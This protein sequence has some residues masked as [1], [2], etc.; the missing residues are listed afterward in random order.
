[1]TG[2]AGSTSSRPS[3]NNPRG[4]NQHKHCPPPDDLRVP[5]LLRAYQRQGISD[6]K[7]ISKLLCEEHGIIMS[8]GTVAR[9]RRELGLRASGRTTAELPDEVKRQLVLDQIGIGRDPEGRAGA[10]TVKARI[11]RETGIDLTRAYIRKEMQRLKPEAY[12]ART[13]HH[14]P[15]DSNE[16][17]TST[18]RSK[19]PRSSSSRV[20]R[21]GSES[22][23]STHPTHPP[24][25]P[26]KVV[27]RLGN[28]EG[29]EVIVID[30][31]SDIDIGPSTSTLPDDSFPVYED[32]STVQLHPIGP[33]PPP[34]LPLALAH[35]LPLTAQL[36]LQDMLEETTP[37]MVALTRALRAFS[38]SQQGQVGLDAPAHASTAVLRCMEAAAMLERELARV[39][40][41]SGS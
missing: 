19:A 18:S 29:D 4:I 12:E 25:P 17:S 36:E 5:E 3:N 13:P 37:K 24:V 27:S 10:E 38:M 7:R 2:N 39:A 26:H 41:V 1:M 22:S 28:G 20:D 11:F 33:P 32:D 15:K 6:R 9:R 31:D 8:E 23:S 14:K 21:R 35:R 16:S 34:P 40:S 30:I